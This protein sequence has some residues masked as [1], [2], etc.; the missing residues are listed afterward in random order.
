MY[1]DLEFKLRDLK[2]LK[3]FSIRIQELFEPIDRREKKPKGFC[4][5]QKLFFFF[6]FEKSICE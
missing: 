1:C 4:S 3:L 5:Y 6:F 2:N